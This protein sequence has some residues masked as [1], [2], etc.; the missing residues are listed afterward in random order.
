MNVCCC[1]SEKMKVVWSRFKQGIM[2]EH[3]EMNFN[4]EN[5]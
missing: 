5:E 3:D 1:G 4:E 2:C